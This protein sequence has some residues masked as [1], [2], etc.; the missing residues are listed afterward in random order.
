MRYDIYL[1]SPFFNEAQIEREEFVKAEL[2]K[3]GLEVFSPKDNCFLPPNADEDAQASVFR[4]N[5][6]AIEDSKA[7]FAI[8]DGK[9]IGTIWESGYAFGKGIPIIFFAETLGDHGFN[10]MLAQSGKHIVLSRDDLK[11]SNVGKMIKRVYGR[12]AYKGAIE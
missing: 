4:Q 12:V 3:Q 1:A 8:T 5:C 10:L 2:K 6:E 7:V 11:K 9:D